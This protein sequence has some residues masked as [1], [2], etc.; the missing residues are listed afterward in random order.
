M[1]DQQQT[2]TIDA[3]FEITEFDETVYDEPAEGPKL[4][5]V[6]IHKRYHGVIDGAGVVDVLTAQGH[7]GAGYVASERVE[8]TLDGRRGTFVIQHGGLAEGTTQ[9]TFGT[10]VP[11]SGTGEL[12]GISG[13]AEEA[14]REILT[15]EY[16]L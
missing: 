10:I 2:H 6:R 5:R 1:D 9:R 12:T 15:L 4:T 16:T 11:G 3:H 7:D 13:R 14:Q 8:G